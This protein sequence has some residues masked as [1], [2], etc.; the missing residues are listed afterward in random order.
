MRIHYLAH[1]T[2]R[3][4]GGM[5][6]IYAHV[7]ALRRHG[8][9]AVVVQERTGFRPRWFDADVPIL[10]G[11]RPLEVRAE[12]ALV[13]PETHESGLRWA[14]RRTAR[15]IVF[16]QNHYYAAVLV[17]AVGDWR[18]F[19]VEQV[20][21][22]SRPIAEFVNTRF[23]WPAPVVVPCVVDP[24]RFLPRPKSLSVAFM[25]QK[26]PVEA[27]LIRLGLS[28][29]HP[30]HADVAFRRLERASQDEVS[31]ALGEAAVFLSLA[32]HEGLG[33]AAL[34][35]MAAEALVVGFHGGGGRDYASDANGSWAE[36]GE[37]DRCVD[38]LADALDRFKAGDPSVQAMR[39]A[40]RATVAR[41]SGAAMEEALVGFWRAIADRSSPAS[42]V[43]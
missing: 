30:R 21:C 15:R 9:D 14:A 40:G 10:Y 34:E 26:R 8:F 36:D 5:V 25:P 17:D 32:H 18:A 37:V 2:E 39:S 13:I 6:M 3:P 33:L 19:G 22:S 16:C 43:T 24:T 31:S 1:D 42:A 23:R 29:R 41:Y 4:T 28:E 35:A 11:D 38:L 12:D 7:A 27:A 20:L